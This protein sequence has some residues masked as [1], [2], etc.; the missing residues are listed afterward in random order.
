MNNLKIPE[1]ITKLLTT[2]GYFERF[3]EF[4]NEFQTHEEAF[5]AVEHQLKSNFGVNK[6]TSYESFRNAKSK[7]MKSKKQ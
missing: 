3:Y 2:K 1:H 5:D 4:V 6:Y 7:F